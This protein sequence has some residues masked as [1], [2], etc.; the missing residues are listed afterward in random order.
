MPKI[1]PTMYIYLHIHYAKDTP[2]INIF[3]HTLCQGYSLLYIHSHI[4]YAKDTP[5]YTHN[6]THMLYKDTSYYT[7]IDT[8]I[9]PKI[10][11]TVYIYSHIYYTKD[12]PY[13]TYTHTLHVKNTLSSMHTF[14]H[15]L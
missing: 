8:H 11:P 3:T 1:L 4:H 6:F 15:I 14:I 2:I 13:Y 7:Y 12:T 9:M 5:Y 10:L